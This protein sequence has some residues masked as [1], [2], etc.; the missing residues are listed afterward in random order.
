MASSGQERWAPAFLALE[1]EFVSL[2]ISCR[3]VC[4]APFGVW[5]YLFHSLKRQKNRETLTSR[6]SIP[7]ELKKVVK[8]LR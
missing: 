8:Y 3:Y 1:F 5:Q 7:G 6:F 2:V 4:R